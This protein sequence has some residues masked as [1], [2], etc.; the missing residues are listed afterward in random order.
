MKTIQHETTSHEVL[1]ALKLDLFWALSQSFE[2][3]PGA[4]ELDKL[5]RGHTIEIQGSTL[6]LERDE[7]GYRLVQN[8][9][10]ILA[11]FNA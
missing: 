3:I 11:C 2:Y 4:V 8:S 6:S 9:R 5:V 1:T 10:R 7:F